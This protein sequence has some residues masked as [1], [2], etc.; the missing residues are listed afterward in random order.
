ML[1]VTTLAPSDQLFRRALFT[2]CG[3][4]EH[5]QDWIRTFLDLDLPDCT[6][7]PESNSNPIDLIWELYSKGMDGKDENFMSVLAYASRDSYKCV[8]KGTFILA[9]SGLKLVEDIRIG[10]MVWSGKA[11]RPVTAWIHDG[12]KDGF[13]LELKNGLTLTGSPIHRVIAWEPGKVPG[14]KKLAELTDRDVVCADTQSQLAATPID[15]ARYDEGYLCGILAG[16][17]CLTQMDKSGAVTLSTADEYVRNFWQNYC[18]RIAG[19]PPKNKK[20]RKY[21]YVICNKAVREH[22]RSLGMEPLYAHEKKVPASCLGDRSRMAGFVSGLLDTDGSVSKQKSLIISLTSRR[23]LE[24]VQT[25]L[26]ALGVNAHLRS[27]KRLY[28]I[29]NHIV[30]TLVINGHDVPGLLRAGI[31]LKTKKAQTIDWTLDQFNVHD[32]IPVVQLRVLL[33]KFPTKKIRKGGPRKPTIAGKVVSRAKLRR[34]LEY[35]KENGYLTN[36]EYTYW[37]GVAANRWVPVKSV[38][39]VVADFYDLTVETDH[40]YWSNGLI[41]HNT[42]STSVMEILGL[43]HMNRDIAH[44]AAIL[45]QSLKA[46]EYVGNF[47]AKPAFYGFVTTDNSRRVEFVRYTHRHDGRILTERE[48]KDLPPDEKAGFDRRMNYIH[49]LVAT[50]KSMNS[51]HVP[52]FVSDETDLAD[53]R[54]LQEGQMIPCVRDGKLPITFMTSTRKTAFGPVQKAIDNAEKSR[55]NIRHWNIVDVA[56]SC[57]PERHRPEEGRIPIWVNRD[58]L[59]AKSDSDFQAMTEEDRKGYT[60][61]DGYHGC[62]RNCRL[63]PACR[64]LLVDRQKSKSPL[65]KPLAVITD[66]FG[67]VDTETA[68]AQL[69][70]L[71]PTSEGLIYPHFSRQVHMRTAAEM[72]SMMTGEAFPDSFGKMD[73]LKLAKERGFRIYAGLD[74]GFT[75]AFAVVTGILVGQNF[76]VVDCIEAPGL[77]LAERIDICDKQIKWLEPIIYPDNED[78]ASIKTFR[79]HGYRMMDFKKDIMAGVNAVRWKL[80]PAL[81]APPQMYFLSGD[82]PLDTM[83]TKLA[84][85]HWK[86]DASHQ[87]MVGTPDDSD[88]DDAITALRYV[89]QNLFGN[90]GRVV[91]AP[92]T[93]SPIVT[94]GVT[95]PAPQVQD[96]MQSY[97]S[98]TL[99][100]DVDY[101]DPEDGVVVGRNRGGEGTGRKGGFVWSMD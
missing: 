44:V 96:W 101:V 99:G 95:N 81:G 52:F 85:Y 3:T 83:L 43:V 51:E 18:L 94:P 67:R 4:R 33:E 53:P 70:C 22:L 58:L 98:G 54:A 30:H 41:S 27:S 31:V 1:D 86:Y 8:E 13:R 55:L 46:V 39:S 20:S 6:V 15:Q 50:V 28:N 14:W 56:E 76:Y 91:T 11:W 42:L 48:W 63:F 32:N 7:D 73:L 35:G 90:K 29:Q 61:L 36:S 69:L 89:C 93:V 88:G 62:L 59:S 25:I 87:P 100:L 24:G 19:V 37:S 80:K 21:D 2:P 23:L 38:S 10:D 26:A 47:L 16:D 68:L 57:P 45:Q 64:G 9:D 49:I 78:P 75:H 77:E 74:H 79:R 40:S 97:L 82:R 12:K 34:F 5:L 65:L 92:D 66:T 71:K 72:A 17:G 60:R 84:Q